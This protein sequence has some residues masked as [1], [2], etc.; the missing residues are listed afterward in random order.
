[1]LNKCL[2]FTRCKTKSIIK[3]TNIF[4]ILLLLLFW[5]DILNRFNKSSK[6]QQFEN[7][8]NTLIKIY[9]LLIT[10]VNDHRTDEEYMRYTNLAIE[11]SFK[12]FNKTVSKRT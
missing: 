3:K 11:I 1:M 2:T 12:N 7:N 9:H 8:L 10:Y 6:K 4:E 5:G